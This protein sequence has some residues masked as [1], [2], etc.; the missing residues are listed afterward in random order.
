MVVVLASCQDWGQITAHD[1]ASYCTAAL[2]I[3]GKRDMRWL[4]TLLYA[5]FGDKLLHMMGPP[6][7]HSRPA[8]T[9]HACILCYQLA[10][11]FCYL[12]C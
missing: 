7:L 9:E 12:A 5:K 2:G 10:H 8:C 1:G 3:T 11:A 6:M 4:W